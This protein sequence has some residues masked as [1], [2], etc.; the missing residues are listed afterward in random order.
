MIPTLTLHSEQD[1]SIN[2]VF[3]QNVGK[4]EARYVQRSPE[5]AIVYL[6]SHVGC[7]LSCKF[8]HLTQTGQTETIQA[9]LD[10]YFAQAYHVMKNIKFTP[11]LKMIHYNFM[12]RG[13][14]LDNDYLIYN[15]SKLFQHLDLLSKA[16]NV[17]SRFL[18]STIIPKHFNDGQL[19]KIFKDPRVSLYYS[20]YSLDYA[21]RKKW[22]PK[23]LDPFVALDLLKELQEV[24]DTKIVLHW[25]FIEGQND[26]EQS[27]ID[28]CN[29]VNQRGLNVR[30]NLV[31]YNP[32]NEKCG[33]ESS[34]ET[35]L[36]LLDIFNT[37]LPDQKHKMVQRVG[38]DVKASC[39]M[40]V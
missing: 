29:E 14:A 37:M 16:N 40:F 10:E 38:F 11:E 27:V 7:D 12:A 21:F 3:E 15:P 20:L 23:A 1:A 22:L 24:N 34:E 35:L 28:I 32:H 25:A 39:G 9:E 30:F 8:C 33:K 31:R 4:F 26:S 36:K 13:D 17:E 19:L 2:Y 5:Y 18:I 6:S